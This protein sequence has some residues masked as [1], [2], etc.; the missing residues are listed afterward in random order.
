MQYPAHVEF[1]A[2]ARARPQLWRLFVGLLLAGAIY[3]AGILLIF[4]ILLITSGP[5][6][7]QHWMASMSLAN[8]PTSTLLLLATFIGMALGPMAAA[9]LL[10]K[11]PALSLFGGPFARLSTH[12]A[13]G[14]VVCA[15][16]YGATLLIPSPEGATPMPNLDLSLWASFLPLALVGVFVQ[17]GAEELL[18]RGYVQQQLAARFRSP[19]IWMALPAVLFGLAHYQPDL[20][21]E[22]TWF[23]VAATGVFALLAAD[24]TAVTGNIGAAWGLHFANNCAAILFVASDGPLSGL[25]L[26]TMP[27]DPASPAMAPLILLDIG[28]TVAIWLVIRLVVKRVRA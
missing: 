28:I 2:P 5:E 12:F 9:K 26:Y 16:V 17:T 22:N 6:G 7:A 3:F 14:A 1:V 27:V 15:V 11:R 10:H 21:G 18:F 24:L 8:G 13:I 23:I 4:G 19:V 20:M 25:A